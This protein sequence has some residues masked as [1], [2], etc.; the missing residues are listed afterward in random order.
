MRHCLH[1][2]PHHAMTCRKTKPLI[3]NSERFARY[4]ISISYAEMA[5]SQTTNIRAYFGVK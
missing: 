1:F 4:V 5:R 2:S 3:P